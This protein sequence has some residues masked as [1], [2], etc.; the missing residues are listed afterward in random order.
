VALAKFISCV[1]DKG[2]PS[3]TLQQVFKDQFENYKFP[4]IS[5]IPYGHFKTSLPFPVGV[6]VRLNARNNSIEFFES[7]VAI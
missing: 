7:G 3:L 6:K 2:K 4:V 5:E 1:P